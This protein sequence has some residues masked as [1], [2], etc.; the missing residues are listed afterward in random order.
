MTP[1]FRYQPA[2]AVAASG[3][4]TRPFSFV[5]DEL[6][7]SELPEGDGGYQSNRLENHRYQEIYSFGAAYTHVTANEG[8]DGHH[9]VM[10]AATIEKLNVLDLVKADL[11]TA[12]L[13]GFHCVQDAADCPEPWIYPLGST[14]MNLRIAGREYPVSEPEGFVLDLQNPLDYQVWKN[15]RKTYETQGES[16]RIPGFGTVTLCR[17]AR[18][19]Q[20]AGAA[21]HLH[22]LTMLDLQL[23]SPVEG[24]LRIGEVAV[25][26]PIAAPAQTPVSAL[27]L[28]SGRAI[29]D[30]GDPP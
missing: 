28:D 12:R 15:D 30:G 17:L 29:D 20:T 11:I 13:V 1:K 23:G 6:V 22:R 3:S 21:S 7:K 25:P 4:L 27:D 18:E 8:P 16:F 14:I 9:N 5:I 19:P 2:K 10:V 26:S 24:T